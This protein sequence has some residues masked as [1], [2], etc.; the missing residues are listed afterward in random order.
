ML[1]I[2]YEGDLEYQH[3]S[4]EKPGSISLYKND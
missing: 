2:G 1:Y 4:I 3:G